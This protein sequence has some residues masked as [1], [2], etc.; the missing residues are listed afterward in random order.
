MALDIVQRVK[1][2]FMSFSTSKIMLTLVVFILAFS[3]SPGLLLTLPK[4]KDSKEGVFKNGYVYTQETNLLAI[5]SHSVLIAFLFYIIIT[6]SFIYEK[7][8]IKIVMQS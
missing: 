3:F 5:S 6:T 7:L 1:Q 4:N 8:G 2:L